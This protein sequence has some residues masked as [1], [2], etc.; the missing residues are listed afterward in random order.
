MRHITGWLGAALLGM[1]LTSCGADQIVT[2][3]EY[4]RLTPGMTLVQA[5]Q[6][7]GDQG[8]PVQALARQAHRW[9]NQDGS[10]AQGTFLAGRAVE[11]DQEGLLAEVGSKSKLKKL[12]K[13]NRR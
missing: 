3:D 11:F 4:T 10:F 6:V 9:Q 2:P 5:Q 12:R 8:Q 7:V 1:T 13:S